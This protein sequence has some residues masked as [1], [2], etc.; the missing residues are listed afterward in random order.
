[1]EAADFPDELFERRIWT[2]PRS[3]PDARA[4]AA[5]VELIRSSS[6]PVVIAGGGVHYS[7]AT[8]TLRQFAD[9]T[10]MPV[11]ETQAG[12]GALPF[13]HRQAVGAM[14]ATGTPCA[15]RLARDADLV[16]VVGSRLGDF[17]TASKTA[18]ARDGVKFVSINVTELDAQKLGAL[19]LVGDARACL[20]ELIAALSGW[21]VAPAYAARVTE[22]KA[23]WEEEVDRIF[24]LEHG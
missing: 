20:T 24:N 14:G 8:D 3:R 22:E 16:L 9:L 21:R 13:D 5:A 15:N 17:T 7:G 18:F 10:G 1:T 23:K 11:A 4:V 19:P 6:R 2:I 12:K